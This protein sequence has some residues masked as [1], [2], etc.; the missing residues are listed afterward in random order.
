[1]VGGE[2]YVLSNS[3]IMKQRGENFPDKMV[4]CASEFQSRIGFGMIGVGDNIYLVGGV[5]GPGPRNQ[6]I[7][8]LSDVDIL[9]VTSE[10][11]TWRPGSPMTHCRGSICGC[12]L[13]R[14]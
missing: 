12:A 8:P 4:S 1:M 9:N 10:R 3:C 11:P 5:I 6:C 2:L 14:I 7:K 13:L